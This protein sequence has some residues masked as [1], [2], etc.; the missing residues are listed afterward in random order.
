MTDTIVNNEART[1]VITMQKALKHP[2]KSWM[3][4]YV[5]ASFI[6]FDR[7]LVVQYTY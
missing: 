3:S 6:E 7:P 4:M 5:V 1:I 2:K